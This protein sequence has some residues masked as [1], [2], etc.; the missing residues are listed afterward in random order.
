MTSHVKNKLSG[1]NIENLD[2]N[3]VTKGKLDAGRLPKIDH[4]TLT[5]KG[6]L[7]HSQIDSLLTQ[8]LQQDSTYKLSDLSIAN[9]LQTLIA[10]KDRK[11]TRLNSSHIP[12]SRMPSSA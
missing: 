5:N 1:E 10:L 11:S 2:L 12:L 6:T 3:K 9:R 7:S 8:Y 4:T